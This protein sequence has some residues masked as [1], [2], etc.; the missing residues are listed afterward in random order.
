MKKYTI[1]IQRV[2]TYQ[3]NVEAE[4]NDVIKQ[5]SD[6]IIQDILDSDM[7]LLDHAQ[8]GDWELIDIEEC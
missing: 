3:A 1:T 6:L 2:F 5:N 8:D 4:S 7:N